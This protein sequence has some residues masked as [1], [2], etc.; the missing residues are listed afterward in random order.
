MPRKS[1]SAIS[2]LQNLG[3]N[4]KKRPSVTI[5]DVDDEDERYKPSPSHSNDPTDSGGDFMGDKNEPITII[6]YLD[7][8]EEEPLP[9]LVSESLKSYF[10]FISCIESDLHASFSRLEK[11]VMVISLVTI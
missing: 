3:Y 6:G 2:R 10:I 1:K 11:T 9:D 4:A 5:E 7:H 8:L